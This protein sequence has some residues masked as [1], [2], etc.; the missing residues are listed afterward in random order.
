MGDGDAMVDYAYCLQHGAG[1]RPD[2][3]LAE[4]EGGFGGFEKTRLVGGGDGEA[5]LD[6]VNC[7]RS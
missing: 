5:V 1:V 3:T 6:D 2:L 7:G 4:V